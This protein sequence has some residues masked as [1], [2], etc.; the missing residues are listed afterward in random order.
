MKLINLIIAWVKTQLEKSRKKKFLLSS[1][2]NEIIQLRKSFIMA[3]NDLKETN[4]NFTQN[5]QN[6][7]REITIDLSYC[8]AKLIWNDNGKNLIYYTINIF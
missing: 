4:F 8:R 5:I 6:G 2:L 3:T 7:E 1:V